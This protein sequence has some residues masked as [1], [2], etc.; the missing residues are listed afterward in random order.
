MLMIFSP[1][2]FHKQKFFV[3]AIGSLTQLILSF[4]SDRI[5]K[6]CFFGHQGKLWISSFLRPEKSYTLSPF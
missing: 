2:P 6:L 1:C 3:V 4:I 5:Q